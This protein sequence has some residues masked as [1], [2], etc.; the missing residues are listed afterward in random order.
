MKCVFFFKKCNTLQTLWKILNCLISFIDKNIKKLQ[1]N[2]IFFDTDSTRLI[3]LNIIYLIHTTS[4]QLCFKVTKFLTRITKH[5][6]SIWRDNYVTV[7]NFPI[8]MLSCRPNL[9]INIPICK[10]ENAKPHPL[11]ILNI[12]LSI[13]LLPTLLRIF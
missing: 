7:T 10:W 2:V 12:L 6:Y 3:H 5:P 13:I 9:I 1:P 11:S 8:Q 4:I